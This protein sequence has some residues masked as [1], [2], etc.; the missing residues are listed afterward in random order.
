M[1]RAPLTKH[2]SAMHGHHRTEQWRVGILRVA[3]VVSSCARSQGN[4]ERAASR[5]GMRDSHA[6]QLRCCK[7]AYLFDKDWA[8]LDILMCA[9]CGY[10][11]QYRKDVLKVLSVPTNE[12]LS[13]SLTKSLSQ[14]D[15]DR[16]YRCMTFH[17]RNVGS[18]RHRKLEN[19][20]MSCRPSAMWLKTCSHETDHE[21]ETW[22]KSDS[23]VWQIEVGQF[24]HFWNLWTSMT[25]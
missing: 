18:G 1:W 14:I 6:L 3:P 9:S 15:Q 13:D 8:K 5:S 23:V 10:N 11:K 24:V 22:H 20:W 2:G 17:M 12:N 25:M 19:T 7:E 21:F 16:C 4:V